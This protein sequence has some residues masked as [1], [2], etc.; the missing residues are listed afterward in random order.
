MNFLRWWTVGLT[1]LGMAM[2][3]NLFIV[4]LLYWI[5]LDAAP[6]MREEFPAVID[7]TLLFMALAFIGALAVIPIFR[8]NRWLWPSQALLAV[9]AILISEVFYRALR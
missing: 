5:Y 8:R 7:S 1:L 9:S 4:C 3:L 6:E 2:T